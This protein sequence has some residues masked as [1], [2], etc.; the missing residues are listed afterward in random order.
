MGGEEDGRDKGRGRFVVVC[1]QCW[2]GVQ[3]ASGRTP[4]Q[5]GGA[6]EEISL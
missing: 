1:P 4:D 6:G 3:V 2:P 5:G